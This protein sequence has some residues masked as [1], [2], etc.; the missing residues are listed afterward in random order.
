MPNLDQR[1]VIFGTHFDSGSSL[2]LWRRADCIRLPY[3]AKLS[4]FRPLLSLGE[5]CKTTRSKQA[6]QAASSSNL[7][8]VIEHTHLLLHHFSQILSSKQVK[9]Q[10]SKDPKRSSNKIVADVL[11]I[12]FQFQSSMGFRNLKACAQWDIKYSFKWVFK[13][14]FKSR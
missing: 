4:A 12:F 5:I 14:P 7:P 1:L 13:K 3:L 10:Q 2:R 6:T 8:P 11:Q 9:I